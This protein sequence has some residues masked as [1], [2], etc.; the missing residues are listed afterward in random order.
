[1]NALLVYFKN[2]ACQR[3]GEIKGA[4]IR[5]KRRYSLAT[6]RLLTSIG[7]PIAAGSYDRHSLQAIAV[8]LKTG[9]AVSIAVKAAVLSAPHPPC[10]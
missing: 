10:G 6:V 3:E 1:M 5:V 8:R 2:V 7:C 4:H 9:I